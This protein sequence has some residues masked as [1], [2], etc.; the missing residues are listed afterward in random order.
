MML[1]YY[2][3]T[4]G[5]IFSLENFIISFASDKKI[6]ELLSKLLEDEEHK[7][8]EEIKEKRMRQIKNVK[9]STQK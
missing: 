5:F 9:K 3:I 7:K 8:L 6:R 4:F 2:F 1:A